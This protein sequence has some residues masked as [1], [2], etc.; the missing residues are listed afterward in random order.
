MIYAHHKRIIKK[1]QERKNA[2]EKKIYTVMI[3]KKLFTLKGDFFQCV[4]FYFLS[5][6]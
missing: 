1:N 2:L 4:E 5:G 3:K 6:F